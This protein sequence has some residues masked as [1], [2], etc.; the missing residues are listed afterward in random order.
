M[1]IVNIKQFLY[2]MWK[3]R[4]EGYSTLTNDERKKPTVYDFEDFNVLRYYWLPIVS[5]LTHIL[6]FYLPTLWLTF[7]KLNNV[8]EHLLP[9]PNILCKDFNQK[10]FIE[11]VLSGK[12]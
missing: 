12:W 3:I 7:L 10:R 2:H 11:V 6:T 9:L 4:A 5:Y 1:I 8:C